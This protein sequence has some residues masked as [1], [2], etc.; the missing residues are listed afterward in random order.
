MAPPRSFSPRCLREPQFLDPSP[1]LLEW[2]PGLPLHPWSCRHADLVVS[3]GTV[4]LEPW[5]AVSSASSILQY[6][7]DLVQT[8]SVKHTVSPC[9]GHISDDLFLLGNQDQL[10]DLMHRPRQTVSVDYF[11][12][13]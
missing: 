2:T 10:V 5:P 7:L 9:Y 11:L 1:F 12:R 8:W 3:M 4:Y 6:T 13:L